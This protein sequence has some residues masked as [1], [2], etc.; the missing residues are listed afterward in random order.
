MALFTL[1][2]ALEKDRELIDWY[3]HNEGMDRIPSLENVT[4]AANADDDCVGL[5]RI[6]VGK[7]GIA[8]VN[9]VV[10]NREWR[11]YGV[12]RALMD[13]AL[14]RY[15]ELRFVARGGAVPFYRALGYEEISW[16]DVDTSVTEECDGCPMID[17]CNPLPMGKKLDRERFR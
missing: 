13:D 17:E 2:P 14:E 7:N 3:L 8:H 12:G 9:P 16:D 1:R 11:G 4:V 15:G 5:C 10:A 6:L